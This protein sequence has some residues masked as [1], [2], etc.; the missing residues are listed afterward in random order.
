MAQ[1]REI[2]NHKK[3]SASGMLV[4]RG[5]ATSGF[6]CQT[7]GDVSISDG[8]ASGG[9]NIITLTSCVAGTWYPCPFHYANGA[10]VTIA[11]GA[12]VT[13]GVG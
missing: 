13:F 11:N 8:I 9:T 7:A 12:V 3:V 2:W 10:Y 6:L 1:V 4:A 5:G